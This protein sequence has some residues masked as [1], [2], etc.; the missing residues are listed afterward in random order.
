MLAVS[1]SLTARAVIARIIGTFDDP[2]DG[3]NGDDITTGEWELVDRSGS[4]V[5]A[6]INTKKLRITSTTGLWYGIWSAKGNWEADHWAEMDFA[7]YTGSSQVLAASLTRVSGG[8]GTGN[9]YGA[10]MDPL[11][12]TARIIK[13]VN[14]SVSN[15]TSTYAHTWQDG[16]SLRLETQGSTH[17][18]YLNDAQILQATDSDLTQGKPGIYGFITTTGELIEV[19]NFRAG[20]FV[21]VTTPATDQTG[22]PVLDQNGA[23]IQTR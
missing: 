9:F 13:M 14:G 23:A 7:A 2:F 1:L 20:I 18:A 8:V 10:T 3:N 6:K 22:S 16:D 4:G 12:G 5:T 15:L 21:Y 19:D 17:T 11:N